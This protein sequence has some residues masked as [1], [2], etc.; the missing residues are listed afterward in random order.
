MVS[1][2]GL[3]SKLGPVYY[4]SRN[5]SDLSPET[6][7]AIDT[8]VRK[9]L[10]ESQQRAHNLLTKHIGKLHKL[11]EKLIVEETLTSEQIQLC[12]AEKKGI[13]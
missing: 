5:R 2:Y 4:D 10:Q 9:L 3:S 8:E 11:A 12:I 7:E 1:T 6:R 13:W